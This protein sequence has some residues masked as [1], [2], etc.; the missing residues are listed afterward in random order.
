MG[1]P[2]ARSGGMGAVMTSTE[3][4]T[5]SLEQAAETFKS[6]AKAVAGIRLRDGDV[7]INYGMDI[8]A[9]KVGI[10]EAV[11]GGGTDPCTTLPY[12]TARM[13][14]DNM[15]T[16]ALYLRAVAVAMDRLVLQSTDQDSGHTMTPDNH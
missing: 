6:Y 9:E 14:R 16:F 8:P 10:I 7:V 1:E 13:V 2:E 3:S 12:C 15:S 5:L 4:L 11:I